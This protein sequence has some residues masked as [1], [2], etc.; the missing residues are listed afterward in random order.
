MKYIY[1]LPFLIIFIAII[2]SVI[3]NRNNLNKFKNS[4]YILDK[5][6]EINIK[7]I[8]EDNI[9]P[10]NI[11]QTHKNIKS[12]PKYVI[13]NIK[14]KNKNWNYFF[15]DNDQCINFLEKEYGSEFSNK[16]NSFKKGPHKSDL[17]RLCW[18]Y[19]NGGVYIDID[20][21]LIVPLDEIVKKIDNHF[22]I[23]QNDFR[24]NYY[25]D[26]I[27]D[28]LEYKHKTLINSFIIVNKGNKM[29]KKC[30][31]NIMKIEQKDLENNYPL[32]LFVMQHTLKNDIEYQIFERSNN[33]YIP[34]KTG[35]MEMYDKEG[36][37]IGY[38]KYKNY[39]EG[40]F[41]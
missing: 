37:K 34:F 22:T 33:N 16:F 30:I 6:K 5:E 41:K 10:K 36:I 23:M 13:N 24:H 38:S 3:D 12:V 29:I 28:N 15:Y 26:L 14:E 9:V 1:Y 32:I 21:E 39:K 19:K 8:E 27:S 7:D 18:L 2:V 35:E 31:E 25:D 4:K 20:T 11:L 40:K 17:F